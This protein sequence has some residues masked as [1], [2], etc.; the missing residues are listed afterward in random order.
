MN[1]EL[2]QLYHAVKINGGD[3]DGGGARSGRQHPSDPNG[4]NITSKSVDI[5][6]FGKKKRFSYV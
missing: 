1:Y 6:F 4:L 3:G 5:V 2:N